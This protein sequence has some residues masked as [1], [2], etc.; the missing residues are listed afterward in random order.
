MLTATPRHPVSRVVAP[1][2]AH[3]PVS[4]GPAVHACGKKVCNDCF[5]CSGVPVSD[6]ISHSGGNSGSPGW[7]TAVRT[8]T[9]E[10]PGNASPTGVERESG[11][12]AQRGRIHDH[13]IHQTQAI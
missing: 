13:G 7:W 1:T 4:T 6:T 10:C 9:A 8:T 11:P 2:K 3:R 5:N 12:F